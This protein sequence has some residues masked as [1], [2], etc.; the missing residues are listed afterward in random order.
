MPEDQIDKQEKRNGHLVDF[1]IQM[2]YKVKIN[3][4]KKLDKYLNL[5]REKKQKKKTTMKHVGNSDT[6]G[7]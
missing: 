6:H 5:A 1:S 3:E 7:S 2:E 4:S